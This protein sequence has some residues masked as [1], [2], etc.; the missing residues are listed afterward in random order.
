VQNGDAKRAASWLAPLIVV[1]FTLP[2]LLYQFFVFKNSEEFRVKALTQTA[3]PPFVDIFLSF[4]PLMLLAIFGTI[5]LWRCASNNI[6]QRRAVVLMVAWAVI[7]LLFT[8]APVSFARK[9]IEGFHLPL[10][11]L[12]AAGLAALVSRISAS[13]TRKLVAGGV[14]ALLSVSSLQFAA[15]CLDNAQ[16]NNRARANVLMPPLYLAPGDAAALRY[17]NTSPATRESAV[18]SLTF[19]GN[20]VPRETG[21]TV[22]LGHWAETL[23]YGQKLGQATR[24]FGIGGR[25][26][27]TADEAQAW[28]REN[29]IG[30]VIIGSY[31]QQLGATLPLSLN[32]LHQENGTTI[33]TVPEENK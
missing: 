18:L 22:Y 32:V 21:R 23:H 13:S 8:Y 33:Y 5:V 7:T 26:Q 29:R 17:L 15:W 2:P 30:I 11:F 9:M 24:F 12:A 25:G 1:A 31:E 14:V 28:L 20:Y 19:L 6:Q 10:C 3:A 16:D 4:A 27:M